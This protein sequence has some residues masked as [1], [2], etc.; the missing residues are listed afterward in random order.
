[1]AKTPKSPLVNHEL[2][3]ELA[4]LLDETGLTEIEI[5]Q[6]GQRVRVARGAPLRPR[7]VYAPRERRRSR[8]A[9]PPRRRSIP[10]S[11]RAW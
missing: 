9:N 11:I 1:M 2:I 3:H 10:P 5:E 8:S 4:K 6:D 7:R